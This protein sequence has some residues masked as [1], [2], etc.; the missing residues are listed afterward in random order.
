MG[1]ATVKKGKD[2]S[3]GLPAPIV[4]RCKGDADELLGREWLLTNG[5]G[6]YASGTV[7]GVNTRRYHGLL[8][9][10]TQP[11]V[12]RIVALSCLLDELVVLPA[13]GERGK[14]AGPARPRTYELS[15]FEFAGTFKPDG[16]AGLVQFRQRE[17]AAFVYR[18]GAGEV[19]KEIV[20]AEG[21]NAVAVRYRLNSGPGGT[22]RIRPFVAMR[23]F[24]SL[25]EGGGSAQVTFLHYHDGVRVEDRP[26]GAHTLYLSAEPGGTF[27]P[28]GQ[29]WYQF[30]Y[31][32]ELA[33]GQEGFEDLYTPGWFE[34][35]LSA[36]RPVQLTACLNERLKVN[37]EATVAQKRRRLKRMVGGLGRDADE[38]TR[39]LAMAADAF[40]VSRQRP[41]EAAGTTILA[42]YHWFA[43]WGRD[44]MIALPGLLLETG[45]HAAALEVLR[46]FA[47]AMDGGMIP[48]RF[49]DYGG[50]PQFNSIDAS[51]WFV[52]AADRYVRASG[53]DAAWRAELAGPVEQILR[54]YRDGTRF[55][56]HAGSDGLIAAG[57]ADTQL[58]WMDVSW[59]G[60]PVTPRHG[61]CVEV[62]ALWYA[63]LRIAAERSESAA[64][65]EA[66][67]AE[68]DRV[69]A[70]FERAFWHEQAGCLYDCLGPGKPDRS[71]RPNQIL[72]VSLPHS[73][74]EWARQQSVVDVVQRELL[75]PRGLRTLSRRDRHYR[76]RYGT[77]CESRDKA[78]HQG[79]VWAWL[80]GPFIEAYLKVNGFALDA[81]AQAKQ[82]LDGFGQH[83]GEAGVGFIS[84]IFDGDEPHAPAGCIAQAWSVGEIL[85]A[86]RLVAEGQERR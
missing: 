13:E 50:P 3:T 62:N 86:K 39:R 9:A 21:S 2:D 82:W 53:D 52:I 57:E 55:G 6:S 75:T 5:L 47:E 44:A 17:S 54:A 7:A 76:G 27:L 32:G 25:R 67:A 24:H 33:R 20:L 68:A 26:G 77:S 37:F 45:Q 84:E 16:R 10:A 30:R 34:V 85:R 65:T 40:V 61:K 72:A 51:L 36:D 1:V 74:L 43:D 19:V 22:L 78:Y 42:G 14:D 81:R 29:W 79:T 49:D 48:N 63:A 23:D 58:T 83:L 35:E 56:I 8:V 73:P 31:R 80:M 66:H 46:T 41:A 28:H 71:I 4:I 69:R 18:C 38:T 11:P 12:G 15:T 59:E 64:E 60:V 70:A